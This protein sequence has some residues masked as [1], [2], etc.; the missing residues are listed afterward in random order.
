MDGNKHWPLGWNWWQC[1]LRCPTGNKSASKEKHPPSESSAPALSS[2][3]LTP[4]AFKSCGLYKIKDGWGGGRKSWGPCSVTTSHYWGVIHSRSHAGTLQGYKCGAGW[5]NCKGMKLSLSSVILQVSVALKRTVG[6][7]DWRFDNW[8]GSQLQSQTDS[9][10]DSDSE[11]L[12]MTTAQVVETSVTVT[13]R[14][15]QK[16]T[17][18]VAWSH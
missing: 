6:D 4:S 18:P 5:G 12:K 2:T 14:S 1:K 11:T 7:S 15:F 17:H 13:N 16:Y 9:E 3:P 10:N 8:S